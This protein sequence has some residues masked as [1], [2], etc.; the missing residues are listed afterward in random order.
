MELL[1][2]FIKITT[3]YDNTLFEIFKR[4]IDEAVI[5]CNKNNLNTIDTY[6]FVNKKIE[7][8]YAKLSIAMGLIP[9]ELS[10]NSTNYPVSENLLGRICDYVDEL[11]NLARNEIKKIAEDVLESTTI[12]EL[13]DKY[14][15]LSRI[16]NELNENNSDFIYEG[17]ELKR[18]L[19]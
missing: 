14:N 18:C 7:L 13:Q 12:E 3:E 2:E 19:K 1:D 4:E 10:Y 9:N 11:S 16:M 17:I 15:K 8:L 6:I 5:H